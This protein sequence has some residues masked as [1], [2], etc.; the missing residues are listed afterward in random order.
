MEM[1]V[2]ILVSNETT[3]IEMNLDIIP[4]GI[5]KI[6]NG[7]KNKNPPEYSNKTNID[8]KMIPDNTRY[9][10]SEKTNRI[11]CVCLFIL[12]LVDAFGEFFGNNII[13]S[14]LS[15]TR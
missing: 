4:S 13:D 5:L 15:G 3:N 7:S 14:N 8:V 10:I 6:Q 11:T 12:I 1:L 2:T 9:E